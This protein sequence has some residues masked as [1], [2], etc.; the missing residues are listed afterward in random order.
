MYAC[1][2]CNTSVRSL[3]AY[4]CHL[5]LHRNA[6]HLRFRCCVG[7]CPKTFAS[8]AAFST[9]VSRYHSSLKHQETNNECQDKNVS[10]HCSQQYCDQGFAGVKQLLCHLK[11]HLADHNVVLCPFSNC[12]RSYSNKS[13]FTSH[14]SRHHPELTVDVLDSRHKTIIENVADHSTNNSM[15]DATSVMEHDGDEIESTADDDFDM[16][17]ATASTLTENFKRSL[18]L[19]YLK[20]KTKHLIPASTIQ[21]IVDEFT[22]V[23]TMNQEYLLAKTKIQLDSL[24][25]STECVAKIL[26]E[27]KNSDLLS[28]CNA[29]DFRNEYLRKK[30]YKQN[31]HYVEPTSFYFGLD[32]NSCLLYTS[33]AADE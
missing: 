19:F 2:I 14:L 13:S 4:V 10:L 12:G 33:D 9:H 26:Q 18:A 15:S 16:D 29:T 11:I 28:H 17:E 1:N 8:F 25:L 7:N 5:R 23:N 21:L 6:S 30:F 27:I 3:K 24:N 32:N 20:L 22:S 31:L